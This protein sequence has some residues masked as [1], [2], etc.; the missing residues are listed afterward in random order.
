MRNLNRFLG[1]VGISATLLAVWPVPAQ[2]AHYAPRFRLNGEVMTPQT[3]SL[4]LLQSLPFTKLDVFF[5]T[6]S[7]PVGAI[8]TGVLLWDLLTKAGVV[9]DPTVKNDILRKRVTVTGSDGYQVV[10]SVG[11]LDPMFGGEQVIAA[12]A[13]NGQPITGTSGFAQVVVPGDKAG[14]RYVFS[15]VDI[16]V[17]A[18]SRR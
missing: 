9:T 17:A 12:Y 4:P 3:Y 11:E 6:G 14:G 7:G 16:R 2:T 1:T 15:V 13:Q 5:L 18:R 10:F 8:Y